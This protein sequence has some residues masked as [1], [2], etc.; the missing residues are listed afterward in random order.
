M[1]PIFNA[2]LFT[3]KGDFMKNRSLVKKQES[4]RIVE[5]DFLK[6]I[7]VFGMMFMNFYIPFNSSVEQLNSYSLLTSLGGRFGALFIFMAGIGL[8]LMNK[9]A[10]VRESEIVLKENRNKIIKRS[11][12]LF[13]I[14]MIFSIYWRADILHYYAFYLLLGLIFVKSKKVTILIT[15]S[16]LPLIFTG[17]VFLFNWETNWN[18]ELLFYNDFYTLKGFF[19]NLL[20]NG[21]HPIIPWFSFFLTGMFVAKCDTQKLKTQIMSISVGL[22]LFAISEFVSFLIFRNGNTSEF[23]FIFSTQAMP[24]MPLY[25]ISSTGMNLVIFYSVILIF[26]KIPRN[27]LLFNSIKEVGKTV[28][29]N[30]IGHLIIGFPI[31]YIA[32]EYAELN[33]INILLFSVVYF[34]LS[35]FAINLWKLKFNNGPLEMLMRKVSG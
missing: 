21:F 23:S 22:V 3:T 34:I 27:G 5:F 24:P 12:F 6:G 31:L 35:V 29:T 9:R 16:I 1:E 8:M 15:A 30:Y 18:W 14:G 33:F 7:A 13:V 20:F 11:I 32:S 25:V 4:S 26:R 2:N 28:M 19:M 10:L 17:L